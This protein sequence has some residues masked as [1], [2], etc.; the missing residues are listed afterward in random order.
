M[1]AISLLPR[2]ASEYVPGLCRLLHD[3]RDLLREHLRWRVLAVDLPVRLCALPCLRDK[4]PEVGTHARIDD[5]DVRTYDGHLVNHRVVD[6]D[7][8]GLLLRSNDDAI[9]RCLAS[10]ASRMLTDPDDRRR[11]FDSQTSRSG[12]DG[13]E[14]VFYLDELSARREDG[15][16]VTSRTPLVQK[17]ETECVVNAHL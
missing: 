2:K 16:G 14:G 13:S 15:E 9:A 4:H 6:E 17:K 10:S 8:R 1:T 12:R 11:T 5:A 7:G 3:I